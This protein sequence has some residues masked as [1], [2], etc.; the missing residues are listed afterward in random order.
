M[1]ALLINGPAAEPVSVVELRQHLRLGDGQDAVLASLIA[2]ARMMVEAQSGLRLIN[3]QWRILL[4][5]WPD[6]HLTLP[7]TP[8]NAVQSIRVLGTESV[9]LDADQYR[10]EKDTRPARLVFIGN[11]FPRPQRAALGIEINVQ[12]GFGARAEDVPADLQLAVLKLAAHWYDVD[13]WSQNSSEQA[14]PSEVA[15]IVNAHRVTRL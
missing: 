1:S 7:L 6:G 11:D 14:L 10:L 12:V 8:V 13:D 9:T 5:D 4:D 15:L 2:A 3:Q